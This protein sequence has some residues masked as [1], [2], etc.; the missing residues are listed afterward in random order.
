MA[1]ERKLFPNGFGKMIVWSPEMLRAAIDV[2]DAQKPVNGSLDPIAEQILRAI[3]KLPEAVR[4]DMSVAQIKIRLTNLSKLMLD[5]SSHGDFLRYGSDALNFH[6]LP[7][8]ILSEEEFKTWAEQFHSNSQG[9]KSVNLSSPPNLRKA[10][11]PDYKDDTEDETSKRHA[12]QLQ[13]NLEDQAQI[14]FINDIAP[15]ALIRT[16]MEDIY[17]QICASVAERLDESG[18]F[19]DEPVWN[20]LLPRTKSWRELLDVM[21]GA[22]GPEF[23]AGLQ[24]TKNL[25]AKQRLTLENF[26]VSAIAAAV[27]TWALQPDSLG[28]LRGVAYEACLAEVRRSE[29][30]GPPLPS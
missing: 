7:K 18:V 5:G 10:P 21:I 8:G 29:C 28:H 24:I 30:P 11:A 16:E 9:K 27:T 19:P 20:L 15:T 1:T 4:N 23:D 6:Y 26:M 12:V 25:Q 2:L 22:E 3:E 13:K 14:S 17:K